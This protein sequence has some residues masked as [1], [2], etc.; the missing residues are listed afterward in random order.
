MME[1]QH[2]SYTIEADILKSPSKKPIHLQKRFR[3][4]S[5]NP[6]I[7]D[8][9]KKA[10]EI[11]KTKK[12]K[13][14]SRS[15]AIKAKLKI[16]KEMRV[17][18]SQ[19]QMEKLEKGLE[20]AAIKR[21]AFIK[22][23]SESNGTL[24]ER[25]KTVARI[26]NQKTREEML[27]VQKNLE[28]RMRTTTNRRARN[29]LVPKSQ[30]LISRRESL[31]INDQAALRIQDWF[32]E[33]KFTPLVRVYRKVAVTKQ[34][35]KEWSFEQLMQ[36]VQN[37]TILKATNFLIIRAKRTVG[38]K[39]EWNKPQR[40][41]LLAY[42]IALH[43]QQMFSEMNAQ[44]QDL[45][46]LAQ[47][48]ITE[49]EHY[50]NFTSSE[51]IAPLARSFIPIFADFYTAFEAWKQKDSQKVIEELVGHFMELDQLW[52]SVCYNENAE[53][54]WRPNIDQHQKMHLT[55]L[56]RYGDSALEMLVDARKEFIANL[57]KQ[58]TEVWVSPNSQPTSCATSYY[59]LRTSQ[60]NRTDSVLNNNEPS[61]SDNVQKPTKND[62]EMFG[63]LLSNEQL[64][65]EIAMDPT[66][67]LQPNVKGEME[68]RVEKIA[69][70]AFSFILE[71]NLWEDVML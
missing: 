33:R 6:S 32:R 53:Q 58:G 14:T 5:N 4:K 69:K 46:S 3:Q 55:R 66:F 9:L 7:S 22:E 51:V 45:I 28:Q 41:L 20:E 62:M 52:V 42:V 12:Q 64:A 27:V 35:A 63:Q 25:A 37:Q 49:L 19:H 68:A 23:K 71:G 31:V 21:Q 50:V 34:K 10:Q 57:E 17:S 43:P 18:D 59:Q 39:F 30:L 11:L 38:M 29:L 40:V 54:E 1:S 60:V 8:T 13:L 24:V 36:K 70:Q 48:C 16:V 15:D 65:H 47:Q 67:K 44:E 61:N 56:K 2:S 26:H